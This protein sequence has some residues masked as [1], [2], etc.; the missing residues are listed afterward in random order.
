[1]V[2]ACN[3]QVHDIAHLHLRHTYM[4]VVLYYSTF[5]I[6]SLNLVLVTGLFSGTV[7]HCIDLP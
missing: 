4:H 2:G 3:V 5:K 7:G 6:D 1:M